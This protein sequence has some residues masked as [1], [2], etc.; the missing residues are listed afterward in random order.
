VCCGVYLNV[1]PAAC[2][3]TRSMLLNFKPLEKPHQCG[4][5]TLLAMKISVELSRAY[6]LIN[7]GPTVLVSSSHNGKHNVMAAAWNMGLDFSPPK[8]AVVIDKSTFTRGLIEASGAFALNVPTQQLAQATTAVGSSSGKD[9]DKFAQENLR[10]FNAE[11]IAAPLVE[12]CA[13]WLECKVIAEP[14]MARKYDLF[15]GE[16]VAAWADDR[17]FDGKRWQFAQ[18]P[19]MRSIH[20]V[21]GGTYFLTGET[22]ITQP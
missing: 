10:Y 14:E 7:H 5:S 13:A 20:H 8:V 11:K 1:Y 12:G 22:V 2:A 3:L 6:V 21:A 17:V 19:Q 15:L 4:A 16:V 18:A 9:V